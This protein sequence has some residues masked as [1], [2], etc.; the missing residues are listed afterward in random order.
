MDLVNQGIVD[1]LLQ[2][3]DRIHM[4]ANKL[5]A[6]LEHLLIGSLVFVDWWQ[7]GHS[8][9]LFDKFLQLPVIL[10]EPF[11]GLFVKD[12]DNLLERIVAHLALYQTPHDVYGRVPFKVVL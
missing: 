12:L 3:A 11:E 1:C 5:L 10:L 2:D 7:K 4:L 8:F 9:F 6:V